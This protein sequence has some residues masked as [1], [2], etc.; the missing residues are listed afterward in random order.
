MAKR[1]A[2]VVLALGMVMGL[3]ACDTMSDAASSSWEWV[4]SPFSD[5]EMS[6]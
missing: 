6:E 1:I 4:S 5:D 3:S 2:G